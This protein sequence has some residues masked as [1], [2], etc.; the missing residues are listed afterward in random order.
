MNIGVNSRSNGF[1]LVKGLATRWV[2]T[3]VFTDVGSAVSLVGIPRYR[4]SSIYIWQYTN[5]VLR[6]DCA[7]LVFCWFSLGSEFSRNIAKL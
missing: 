4:K 5:V 1:G 6:C 7:G 2:A 3:R